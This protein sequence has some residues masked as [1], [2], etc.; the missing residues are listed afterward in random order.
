[1]RLSVFLAMAP[2]VCGLARTASADQ[3]LIKDQLVGTWNLVSLV[4]AADG[5]S[6]TGRSL[7]DQKIMAAFAP[8]GTVKWTVERRIIAPGDR[9]KPSL[10]TTVVSG[11]YSFDETGQ[12]I[13]YKAGLGPALFDSSDP[14][15]NLKID[16]D[17][18]EQESPAAGRGTR[19]VRS[20]WERNDPKK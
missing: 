18:L 14:K 19:L 1:M 5:K 7:A 6:W 16:G 4:D 10:R 8:D 9:M 3:K 11:T 20:R 13:L 12:S 15:M 2:V 17:K